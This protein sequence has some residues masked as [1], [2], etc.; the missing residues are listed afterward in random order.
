MSAHLSRE[1]LLDL[2]LGETL[3]EGE[4]HLESCAHCREQLE[5]AREGLQLARRDEVPEPAP[6]Y[7]ESLRRSVGRRIAEEPA[8]SVRGGRGWLLSLAAALVAAVF[9]VSHVATRRGPVP[10]PLVSPWSALPSE[11]DDPGLLV[12][13]GVVRADGDPLSWEEGRGLAPFLAGLSE[14]D[15]G[16]LIEALPVGS[17]KGDS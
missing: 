9:A 11:R 12:L 3:A 5:G 1:A 2:A 15:S 16:A 6:F 8:A 7:W 17:R 13:E 4:A 14:A 10:S